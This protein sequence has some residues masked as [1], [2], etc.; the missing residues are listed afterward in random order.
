MKKFFIALLKGLRVILSVAL[1]SAIAFGIYY[2]LDKAFETKGESSISNFKSFPKDSLDVLVVGSSHGQYSFDPSIFYEETGLYSYSLTSA[3]QPLEVSYYFIKETLKKHDIKLVI[4]EGY[5]VTPESE[6][7]SDDSCYVLPITALTGIEKYKVIDF[8]SEEKAETYYF[9][10]TNN[11]NDWKIKEDIEFLKPENALKKD[12]LNRNTGY[13]YR[14]DLNEYPDNW[15]HSNLYDHDIEAEI[16]PEVLEYLNAIYDLCKENNIALFLYKTQVDGI[17]EYNQSVRHLL[18]KWADE[19]NIPYYDFID[20]LWDDN[21]YINIHTDSFHPY[22]NGAGIVTNRIANEIKKMNIDFNHKSFEE[23]DNLYEYNSRINLVQMTRFEHDP[24]QYFRIL[25][26]GFSGTIYLR[27]IGHGDDLCDPIYEA[28]RKMGISDFDRNKNCFAII[29]NGKLISISDTEI[30]ET[31]NDKK[32]I[33]NND[34]IFIADKEYKGNT[35]Y[36]TFLFDSEKYA[37]DQDVMT[38]KEIDV[39]SGMDLGFIDY[40]DVKRTN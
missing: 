29:N 2:Y 26:D 24:K 8:L 18:W 1:I 4:L 27:F 33:I 17:D 20:N 32:V 40:D 25:S 28:L 5:R 21:F 12:K 11:H 31:Y 30:N 6:K 35:H 23:L 22:I 14:D 16:K 9:P 39:F 3:C 7:C 37:W 19:R 13:I 15:W 38:Y 34:G 36:L 10:L